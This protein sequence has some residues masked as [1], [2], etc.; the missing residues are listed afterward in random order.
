MHSKKLEEEL[1]KANEAND[2]NNPE[3]TSSGFEPLNEE[4][5]KTEEDTSPGSCTCNGG[6]TYVSA[7]AGSHCKCVGSQSYSA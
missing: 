2:T 1:Q 5:I 6:A 3:A 4:K 7:P